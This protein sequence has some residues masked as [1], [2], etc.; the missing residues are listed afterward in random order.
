[1]KFA[2]LIFKDR[3]ANPKFTRSEVKKI[4]KSNITYKHRDVQWNLINDEWF[5]TPE[6]PDQVKSFTNTMINLNEGAMFLPQMKDGRFFD[7]LDAY[8]QSHFY[9]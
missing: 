4:F 8:P 6:T 3:N 7:L 2:V 5:P 9:S 1:M